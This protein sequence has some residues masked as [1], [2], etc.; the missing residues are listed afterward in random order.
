M[1][2]KLIAEKER[3]REALLDRLDQL[4]TLLAALRTEAGATGSAPARKRKKTQQPASKTPGPIQHL[5]IDARDMT[6]IE[7]SRMILEKAGRPLPT[8]DLIAAL[9]ASGLAFPQRAHRS[10]NLYTTLNRR[11]DLFGRRGNTWVLVQ[12][13]GDDNQRPMEELNPSPTAPPQPEQAGHTEP[14]PI[15]DTSSHQPTATPPAN[16]QG[17]F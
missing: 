13:S 4:D 14:Q 15:A 3:E 8:V 7:A 2:K 12:W 5:T 17:P 1:L 9:E 6:K 10:N 11:K 16:N